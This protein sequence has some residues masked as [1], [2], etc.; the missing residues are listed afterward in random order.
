MSSKL[1][2]ITFY[3]LHLVSFPRVFRLQEYRVIRK[4]I[5]GA[6][7]QSVMENKLSHLS[8]V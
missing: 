8:F 4:K 7:A 6:L 3:K 1:H 5:E 2:L